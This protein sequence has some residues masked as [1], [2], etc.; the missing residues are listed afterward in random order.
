MANGY[1]SLEE[2]CIALGK[3]T[4]QVKALVRDGK[5]REV[6][7][8][9]KILY[10]K[11]EVDSIAAKEGSSVVDLEGASPEV[12]SL[13][14]NE[15]FAS[16]LSNLADSSASLGVLDESPE[17]DALPRMEPGERSG[18]AS[19]I[20]FADD[21]AMTPSNL[22]IDDIPEELPAA[23]PKGGKKTEFSS[24]IDLLPSD[25]KEGSS[26]HLGGPTG[27]MEF[28]DVPDLGLSGSSII[29]LEPGD[30][31]I[32]DSPA[33]KEGTK[34]TRA[35]ISVFDEEEL[36]VPSDPMGETQISSGFDEMDSVGSGSGL[37]DLTQ[38][39][40]DTSLGA[41]LLDVISP[42]EAGETEVE[43]TMV[44]D[45][46]PARRRGGTG[47]GMVP[48]RETTATM[49]PS[50]A[51]RTMAD[52]PGTMPLNI[53]LILGM[54]G[55]AI[56]GLATAAT[57]QGAWPANILGA[58]STGVIHMSVFLGL[59]VI[60]LGVGIWGIMAGRK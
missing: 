5:L 59:L 33:A 37:L 44:E 56:L 15:S 46:A 4:N 19:G 25:E 13:D 42:T 3:N 23:K 55:V 1:L 17:S 28:E 47:L 10:K 32:I 43:A 60:A 40:D 14:D 31:K 58:I 27:G 38:E 2:V 36:G 24:E 26:M 16:A 53:C 57:L 7:D 29:S 18:S 12:I 35:G 45:D 34:V 30:S 22:N 39:S 48:V 50:M 51:A 9:G 52:D 49:A 8:A 41:E 11:S 21:S 54:L 6:R 20:S